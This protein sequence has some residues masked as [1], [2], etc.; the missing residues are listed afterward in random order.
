[1]AFEF[2]WRKQPVST[3]Y[4]G[5]QVRDAETILAEQRA[6]EAYRRMAGYRP[7]AV[8]APVPNVQNGRVLP[9]SFNERPTDYADAVGIDG[10][11]HDNRVAQAV[12]SMSGYRPGTYDDKMVGYVPNDAATAQRGLLSDNLSQPNVYQKDMSI[13][14]VRSSYDDNIRLTAIEDIDNQIKANNAKIAEL[15][16]KLKAAK[17]N[18]GYID[19]LDRKLAANRVKANDYA[20]AQTHLGRIEARKLAKEQRDYAERMAEKNKATTSDKARSEAMGQIEELGIAIPGLDNT[21]MKQKA[22]ARYN[23]L[24]DQYNSE[25]K[26][27]LTHY[28]QNGINGVS[29]VTPAK[30]KETLKDVWENGPDG[31]EYLKPGVDK[32]MLAAQVYQADPNGENAEVQELWRKIKNGQSFDDYQGEYTGEGFAKLVAEGFNS[33]KNLFNS[34]DFKKQIDD[35]YNKMKYKSKDDIDLYQKIR[36]K[37]SIPKAKEDWNKTHAAYQKAVNAFTDPAKYNGGKVTL[38]VNGKPVEFAVSYDPKN[39][40]YVL[41]ANSHTIYKKAG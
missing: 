22:I 37:K 31:K 7:A 20:N 29:F 23:R 17:A 39:K 30:V 1:M 21:E 10:F 28:T 33:E 9:V 40:R 25:Y 13:S 3:D 35:Y 41:K 16:N 24:V 15:E 14:D 18:T 11:P 12:A 27:N 4:A 6:L 8:E 5:G 34:E 32:Y 19:E 36:G 26:G 38:D 2:N